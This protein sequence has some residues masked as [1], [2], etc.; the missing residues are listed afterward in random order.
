[1]SSSMLQQTD[2]QR[3]EMVRQLT[4]VDL[5]DTKQVTT[6]L[7]KQAEMV[8]T[9]LVMRAGEHDPKV[10]VLAVAEQVGNEFAAEGEERGAHPDLV[11][12]TR[13]FARRV[14]EAMVKNTPAF[15]DPVTE[16]TVNAAVEHTVEVVISGAM[17]GEP[18]AVDTLLRLIT[19]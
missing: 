16:K 5:L 9:A 19:D 2:E 13:I 6:W 8:S 17:R 18:H 12:A 1:M 7:D 4:E 3:A 15:G 14:A 11:A 10:S